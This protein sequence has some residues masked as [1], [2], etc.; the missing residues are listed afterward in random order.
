[1]GIIEANVQFNDDYGNKTI[2]GT[3]AYFD[4]YLLPGNGYWVTNNAY[5]ND[6]TQYWGNGG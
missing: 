6:M 5:A 2:V 1:M 3:K 4:S